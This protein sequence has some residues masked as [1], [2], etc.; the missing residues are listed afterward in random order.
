MTLTPPAILNAATM[1]GLCVGDVVQFESSAYGRMM[2]M[3]MGKHVV[4]F[5][6]RTGFVHEEPRPCRNKFSVI[7]S[8]DLDL[9]KE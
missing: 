8:V 5:M 6:T 2:F 9:L 3:G 7:G 1:M 4:R